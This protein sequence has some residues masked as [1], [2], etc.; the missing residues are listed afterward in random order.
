[1]AWCTDL[2]LLVSIMGVV[3]PIQAAAMEAERRMH[4]DLWCGSFMLGDY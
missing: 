4:D 1:M 3:S 2:E